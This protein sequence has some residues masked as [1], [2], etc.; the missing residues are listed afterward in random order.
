MTRALNA[1]GLSYVDGYHQHDEMPWSS[2]HEPEEIAVLDRWVA[3]LP[4]R[5]RTDLTYMREGLSTTE[6]ARRLGCSQPQAWLRREVAQDALRWAVAT[7]PMLTPSDVYEA[8][9]G[10]TEDEE[11]AEAA[12]YYW[13]E[14]KTTDHPTMKQGTMWARLF[15]VPPMRRSVTFVYRSDEGQIGL[16]ARALWA[17]HDRPG[18]ILDRKRK[19]PSYP[20]WASYQSRSRV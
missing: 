4:P 9:L 15:G 12:R 6:T 10:A 16:V 1:L 18:F 7:L 19:Q 20:R 3:S 11:K 13:V 14:W 2:S 8:V 5:Y 17:I